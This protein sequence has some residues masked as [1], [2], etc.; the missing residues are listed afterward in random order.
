MFI[1]F[2]EIVLEMSNKN[3]ESLVLDRWRGSFVRHMKQATK[4]AN[5]QGHFLGFIESHVDPEG[6]ICAGFMED[7]K[8]KTHE[9]VIAYPIDEVSLSSQFALYRC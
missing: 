5:G 8:S 7:N 2:K 9:E 1:K 3:S 6:L 4:A